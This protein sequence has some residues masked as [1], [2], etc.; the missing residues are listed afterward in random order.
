MKRHHLGR[1][2]PVPLTVALFLTTACVA[3][4]RSPG[5]ASTSESF[6]TPSTETSHIESPQ[7]PVSY[8][9]VLIPGPP[10]DGRKPHFTY[11]DADR[12][13][14]LL[15]PKSNPLEE[16]IVVE[17]VALSPSEAFEPIDKDC[18]NDP[19]CGGFTFLRGDGTCN[20]GILWLRDS[21]IYSGTLRLDFTATCLNR[22][23]VLCSQLPNDPPG[24]GT[25]VKFHIER[26]LTADDSDRPT[27]TR[28]TPTSTG[29]TST[30]PTST[31]PT[32]TGPT[33]TGPTSTGPGP[34]PTPDR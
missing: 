5:S 16:D 26:E 2:V 4:D 10:T 1:L 24:M 13:A 32:S 25:P 18:G 14:S 3:T 17:T 15:F 22:E 34:T 29:P 23:D 12:C 6:S 30:G 33:S 28:P 19:S 21:R 9:T 31:G 7:S 27:P 8:P 11:N 20:I